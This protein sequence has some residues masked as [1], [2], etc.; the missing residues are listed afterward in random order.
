M[1][2]FEKND[3][4][5]MIWSLLEEGKGIYF[6]NALTGERKRLDNEILDKDD[7]H[8]LF[9]P[10]LKHFIGDSY[11]YVDGY[12]HVYKYNFED[13][14]VEDLI[15]VKHEEPKIGDIRCDLHARYHNNSKTISFDGFFEEYRA[16][17]Q[18]DLG[19]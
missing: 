16:I 19:E 5:F 6:F 1:K 15:K 11:P 10:N 9:S 12:R 2:T 4:E 17:Y 7:I 3:N 18:M 8:C 14:S 13:G